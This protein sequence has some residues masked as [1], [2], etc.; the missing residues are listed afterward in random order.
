MLQLVGAVFNYVYSSKYFVEIVGLL[1][2]VQELLHYEMR[3]LG[4]LNQAKMS[5]FKDHQ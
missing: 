5:V 2:I 3:E 1:P 4:K